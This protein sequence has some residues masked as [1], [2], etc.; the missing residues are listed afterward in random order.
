MSDDFDV[1]NT[2]IKQFLA[3]KGKDLARSVTPNTSSSQDFDVEGTNIKQFLAT[4]NQTPSKSSIS[5]VETTSPL[6]VGSMPKPNL[7]LVDRLQE[8]LDKLAIGAQAF[9]TGVEAVGTTIAKGLSKAGYSLLPKELSKYIPTSKQY[10]AGYDKRYHEY[11]KNKE[12]N[13]GLS[14]LNLAGTVGATSMV[15]GSMAYKGLGTAGEVALGGLGKLLGNVAGGALYG[16]AVGGV[17]TQA[18]QGEDVLNTSGA[19]SGAVVGGLLGPIQGAISNSIDKI[20][21]YSQTMNQVNSTINGN[22]LKFKGPTFDATPNFT[23]SNVDNVL[24]SLP[25]YLGTRNY[26]QQ[27]NKAFRPYIADLIN[28][29]SNK[30]VGQSE[31]TVAQ[32]LT[33]RGNQAKQLYMDTWSALPKVFNDAGVKDIPGA[34]DKVSQ[35]INTLKAVGD[36]SVNGVAD[37]LSKMVN[38]PNLN[39]KDFINIKQQIWKD[40]AFLQKQ[41]SNA[42]SGVSTLQRDAADNLLNTYWG[43]VDDIGNAAKGTKA[44]GAFEAA[45]GIA[46]SYNTLYDSKINPLLVNAVEDQNAVQDFIKAMVNPNT[47]LSKHQ[48]KSYLGELGPIGSNELEA[49]GLR[50]AAKVANMGEMIDNSMN[51]SNRSLDL[52]K[53]LTQVQERM[54]DSAH[55]K[56][57]YAKSYEALKGLQIIGRNFLETYKGAPDQLKGSSILGSTG[58]KLVAGTTAGSM[59][60]NYGAGLAAAGTNPLAAAGN[61]VAAH[62][63]AAAIGTSIALSTAIMSKWKSMGGLT[64]FLGNISAAMQQKGVQP[65]LMQFMYQRANSALTRAGIAM[66]PQPDGSVLIDTKKEEKKPRQINGSL[67]IMN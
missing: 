17:T 40:R 47:H 24:Q 6:P 54:G 58:A 13:S 1:E 26:L 28:A 61:A 57:I 67:G 49:I 8:G 21:A 51:V 56:D 45:N 33:K 32:E 5:S 59:I 42:S 10:Q 27:E 38:K 11:Q 36:K 20:P 62:P 46:R 30:T 34:R 29:V 55:G 14:A 9:N 31:I 37:T 25:S 22:Q 7:T 43:L 53:F 66:Y 52:G 4:Q 35:L 18:G 64:N 41:V 48:V 63:V 23:A 2:N 39:P 3:E 15:P 44:E 12:T 50:K 16:A 19:K 60:G 65:E